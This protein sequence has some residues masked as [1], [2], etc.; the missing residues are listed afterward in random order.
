M[1]VG[2]RSATPNLAV[3]LLV[4][5]LPHTGKSNCWS[6]TDQEHGQKANPKSFFFTPLF[7]DFPFLLNDDE[8][9]TLTALLAIRF[10]GMNCSRY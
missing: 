1:L 10:R 2:S 5:R 7:I 8:R 4:N 3:I 9:I 6:K